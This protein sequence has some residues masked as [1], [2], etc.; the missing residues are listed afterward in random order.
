MINIIEQGVRK[1]LR[2]SYSGKKSVEELYQLDITDLDQIYGKL[3]DERE[4]TATRSLLQT[5]SKADSILNLKIEI[6][7]YII[8]TKIEEEEKKA[9]SAANKLKKKEKKN[10]LLRRLEEI[11]DESTKNLSKEEVLKQIEELD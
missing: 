8:E 11:D 4:K 6:V 10:R 1:G 7:K 9:L 2:F 3:Y 5:R